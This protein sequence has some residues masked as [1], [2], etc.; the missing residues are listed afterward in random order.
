MES[1]VRIIVIISGLD[2][3]L[4]FFFHL[5]Q[6]KRYCNNEVRNAIFSIVH[7]IDSID[8]KVNETKIDGDELRESLKFIK[9]KVSE[10]GKDDDDDD[11]ENEN[12][13]EKNK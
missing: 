8:S 7:R 6:F 2:L 11:G 12:E 1:I 3:L 10:G 5:I 9:R 4:N 13:D